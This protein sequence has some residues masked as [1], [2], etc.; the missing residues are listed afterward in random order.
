MTL[1]AGR[2]VE[3]ALGLIGIGKPW[4]FANPAVPDVRQAL[5]LLERAFAL[6][7]RDF[8]TAP[9]YGVSEER[10]GLFLT[11]LTPRE[12][13]AVRIAT[14]F[15]EHWD[16]ARAEPFV[17]HSLDALR[18]SLDGSVTR[19]G[20]ID[21]LQLHKTTP[22]VLASSDLARAWEYAATLGITA[23]GASVSD[24]E[25]AG[26]AIANPACRILQFPYN[27]AQR[28][29]AGVLDQAAARGMTIAVN[30][31]F[32]MGRMLYE[33]REVSKA[34]AFGLILEKRFEGV[35][36]SGTKSPDHLEENWRAFGEA[37]ARNPGH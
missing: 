9:S 31:P 13:S 19:L 34:E 29:F 15:G 26:I 36:L 33:N 8:D 7:V 27:W 30:R 2:R 6:G 32:A 22:Q 12:R 3:F 4:G 1:P 37:L 10:L 11:S 25:S 17:D 18:R 5:A 20:R 23:I 16:A 24:L 21:F 14:K 35:I 28:T